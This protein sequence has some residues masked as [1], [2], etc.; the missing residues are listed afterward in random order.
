MALCVHSPGE[1]TH[2][3]NRRAHCRADELREAASIGE[4]DDVMM[5]AAV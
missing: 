3:T 5:P 1:R 4:D 2:R